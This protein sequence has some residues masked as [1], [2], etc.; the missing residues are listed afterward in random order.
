MIASPVP[1]SLAADLLHEINQI[2]IIDPH[3]HIPPHAAAAKSLDDL[4]SYHYFT[5][6]AHSLGMPQDCLEK[7]Y[8]AKDRCRQI[9]NYVCRMNNTVQYSWLMRILSSCLGYNRNQIDPT[10]SDALF[11]TSV[12]VFN[13][14]DWERKSLEMGPIDQ[15]FLTNDFDDPLEGFDTHRYV[16][17][18]RTDEL[19]FHWHKP[20]VQDR[21]AGRTGIQVVDLSSLRKALRAL[22]EHFVKKGARACAISLPPTFQAAPIADGDWENRLGVAEPSPVRSQGIFW[23]IAKCCA[24]FGLP[25]D[26]MFG[27]NRDVFPAGVFQGRD[28]FDQRISMIQLAPLFNAFPGVKFPVSVL[29]SPQNAELVA[30]SWIFPNVYVSGHWWYANIPSLIEQDLRARLHAVPR[31][32]ILGYY[33]DMYKLEFGP[34]KYLMFKQV[35]ARVLAQDYVLP[36]AMSQTEAI[37]LAKD[38]LRTNPET[39][40][41]AKTA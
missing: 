23:E 26:L 24:D 13:Q 40:F 16:P 34:P 2:R 41:P 21:L 33:S 38:L 39:I 36:G 9:L 35:L 31:G 22:F 7:S 17:C 27:V 18:L 3:S 4:L 1:G 30:Y 6:L 25:F 14:P 32:K 15:V 8:P 37:G 5:E 10:D 28:L 20:G 19:V 12:R 29:S 11:E